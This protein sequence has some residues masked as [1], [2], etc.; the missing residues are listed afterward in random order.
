MG[1]ISLVPVEIYLET[2]YRP[3]REYI[4]GEVQERNVGEYSHARLQLLLGALFLSNEATWKVTTTVDW[5]TQVADTR[6][7]VPDVVVVDAGK[8]QESILRQ[9]PLLV[10]EILS[11]EDTFTKMRQRIEDFQRFGIQHIWVVDPEDRMGYICHSPSFRKWEATE[12]FS[13]PERGI[14][15]ALPEIFS[16]M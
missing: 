3:D 4:D 9:P 12:R 1:V 16:R 13:I 10:I 8:G 15:V 7:R 5:R 6:F 14:E 2:T 11:P